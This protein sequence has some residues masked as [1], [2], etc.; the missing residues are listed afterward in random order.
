M[1]INGFQITKSG[2]LYDGSRFHI[3]N[4]DEIPQDVL[5]NF[6]RYYPISQIEEVWDKCE[7]PFKFIYDFKTLK[8]I[9]GQGE[10]AVFEQ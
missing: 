3:L 9:V 5:S 10:N 2:F 6:V 1:I 7:D 8:T 4:E